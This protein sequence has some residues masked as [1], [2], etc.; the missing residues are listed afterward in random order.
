MGQWHLVNTS[1]RLLAVC[2]V[3]EDHLREAMAIGGQGV[4]GYKDFREVLERKDI[5]VV[6]IATPPHWHGLMTVAAARAGKD[7]WCEKPMTRTIAEGEKV[8]EAVTTYGRMFRINTWFR[9]SGDSFYG[10]GGTVPEFRQLVLS[11]MLGWPITATIGAATGFEWKFYWSGRTDLVPEWIPPQL[12]YDMWLG[13]APYKPYHHHRVHQTFRGY[14]DYD[15]GG[16]GDMGQ[17][18]IDPVQYIL[19]KDD[20]S[21]VEIEVDAPAQHPEAATSFRRILIRYADGCRIVLEGERE[22]DEIPFLDG[23][24]GKLFKGFRCTIPNVKEKLAGMAALEPT[25][26]DFGASVRT[27]RKFVLNENNGHRS[28]TLVNLSKIAWQLGR[29]IRFDPVTQRC[30]DDEAA[31]RLI[32]PPKR[33]PWHFV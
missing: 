10:S 33:S 4:K 20:E 30:K 29:A 23:P 3:D 31:N 13:P 1:G 22:H 7:I 8:V 15:G 16:L 9:Y 17:H 32:D 12:D 6:H 5:D 24:G 11:G 2:D 28:C 19:G 14:W 18:Y 25:I 26:T 21:P 27:R